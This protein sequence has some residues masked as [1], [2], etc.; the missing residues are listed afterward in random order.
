MTEEFLYLNKNK[1][2]GCEACYEVCP[3]NAIT[4]KPDHEGFLYP[5]IDQQL[6]VDCNRCIS[7]CQIHG[8][9]KRERLKTPIL[10]AVKNKDL[11]VR[12]L[13]SSG[14]VFALLAD[15]IIK[16]EGS[17]IG[18]I[19]DK[20]Y[21]I[22]H[23]VARCSDNVKKMY[24]SKYVQS[25]MREMYSCCKKALETGVQV[26]FTGT[27]CQIEGLNKF[28]NKQYTN[29][30]TVD[31]LCHGVNSPL[32]Y[33]DWLDYLPDFIDKHTIRFRSKL[34]GWKDSCISGCSKRDQYKTEYTGNTFQAFSTLFWSHLILRP[35]CY[36]CDFTNTM[37]VADITL[38]DFWGADTL[39]P[40]FDDDL[41][42][43][44]V[45]CNTNKGIEYFNNIK[46]TC[47]YRLFDLAKYVPFQPALHRRVNVPL[48][49]E[50][51][52][53][54]YSKNGFKKT[55]LKYVGMDLY[56]RVTRYIRRKCNAAKYH[57]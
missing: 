49:R 20:N 5:V 27:P 4:M 25:T 52:W 29:L 13:S 46:E 57:K 32:I 43:S 31:L 1:C 37:R 38:G 8:F 14:G 53:T 2:T 36:Q 44:F 41:G 48:E 11:S 39:M 34:T 21:E 18:V 9:S 7:V 35:C 23:A 22:I 50:C 12:K 33:K 42:I 26:L 3:V 28:L 10:Y 6:C 24:G 19:I 16:A 15:V 17:V 55:I 56:H 45:L 40:D 47:D 54:D 51:F 30:L